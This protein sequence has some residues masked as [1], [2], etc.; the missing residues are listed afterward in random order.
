MALEMI[1]CQEGPVSGQ[2]QGLRRADTDEHTGQQSRSGGRGDAVQIPNSALRIPKGTGDQFVEVR[3]MGTCGNFG[4]DTAIRRMLGQLRDQAIRQDAAPPVR[5]APD[6][7]G[8]SLVAGG[9]DAENR[10]SGGIIHVAIY[11]ATPAGKPV[12]LPAK[13]VLTSRSAAC[14]SPDFV[15]AA[16]VRSL[17]SCRRR[18][19]RRASSRRSAWQRSRSRSWRS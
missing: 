16:A 5:C 3:N 13:P 6:N 8:G 1:D 17:H 2:G 19:S 12:I 9:L 18:R 15:S 7:G 11:L 10:E 14:K 4:N